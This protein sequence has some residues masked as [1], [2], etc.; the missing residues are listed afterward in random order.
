M[1]ELLSQR[2][3]YAPI[4]DY[5]LEEQETPMVIF[6]TLLLKDSLARQKQSKQANKKPKLDFCYIIRNFNIL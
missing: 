1:A 2:K 6:H 5:I 4:H 3:L